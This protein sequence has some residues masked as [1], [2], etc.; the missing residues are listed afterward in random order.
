[1]V[2]IITHTT[3]PVPEWH[4]QYGRMQRWYKKCEKLNKEGKVVDTFESK[5]VIYA[6]FQNCYHLKDWIKNDTCIDQQVVDGLEDAINNSDAMVLC[7]CLANSTKHKVLTQ[8]GRRKKIESIELKETTHL[9]LVTDNPDKSR[10]RHTLSVVI[11]GKEPVDCIELAG[12]CIEFWK[13]YLK[14]EFEKSE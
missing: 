4:E 7:G 9:T 5:D 6:F 11:N 10:G 2:K 8:N 1:M 12:R 13:E 3:Q 14:N